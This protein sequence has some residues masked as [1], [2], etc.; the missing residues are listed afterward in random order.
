MSLIWVWSLWDTCVENFWGQKAE[1][2]HLHCLE[3]LDI[4]FPHPLRKRLTHLIDTAV[5]NWHLT[6][7][8]GLAVNGKVVGNNRQSHKGL[9]GGW[10]LRVVEHQHPLEDLLILGFSKMPCCLSVE[11]ALGKP[12]VF[13]LQCQLFC[14]DGTVSCWLFWSFLA[15]ISVV[16]PGEKILTSSLHVA[17]ASFF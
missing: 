2:L 16:I 4:L 15:F 10:S 8:P 11:T 6:F 3:L 14:P 13:G 9:S 7:R 17:V 5:Q 1:L 12:C